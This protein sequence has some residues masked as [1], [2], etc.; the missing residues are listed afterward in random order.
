MG[1]GFSVSAGKLQAGSQDVS[2]LLKQCMLV[3]EDAVD[4]LAGMAG[5]AGHAGLA[6]ALAG[7]AGQGAR[8]FWGLGAAYQ[9][10]GAS[11]AATSETYAGTEK[12]ISARFGAILG[13]YG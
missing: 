3:A 7:A 2:G 1:Q 9:H 10:V 8:T 12:A 5:S 4:A 6:S 13:E 11:L